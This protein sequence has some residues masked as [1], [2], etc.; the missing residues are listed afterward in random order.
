MSQLNSGHLSERFLTPMDDFICAI[1][2]EVCHDTSVVD[3]GHIFCSGC[4]NTASKIVKECPTCRKH[5]NNIQT[6][7]WH[8]IKI[9]GSHVRCIY[10]GCSFTDAL[11][12]IESHE[13]ECVFR[14]LPCS[15]CN[16][17]IL[18][19]DRDT[20]RIVCRKRPTECDFCNQSIAYDEMNHHVQEICTSIP[21]PCPNHCSTEE[22]I[23]VMLRDEIT[24]HR[25]TCLFEPV[26][27]IYSSIGCKTVTKRQHSKD[28]END[29]SAHF[30]LLFQYTKEHE[31]KLEKE[32]EQRTKQFTKHIEEHR[33]ITKR[34]E[35]IL[36]KGPEKIAEHLHPLEL[37]M[38]LSGH[39]CD[40][41]NTLFDL[42]EK[43][44]GYRCSVTCDYDLCTACFSEK[45]I[46]KSKAMLRRDAMYRMKNPEIEPSAYEE[47]HPLLAPS[48]I[49]DYHHP[50]VVGSLVKRGPMWRWGNQDGE[51]LGKVI[52]IAEQDGWLT[53]LWLSTQF[54]NN[55]RAGVNAEYDLVYA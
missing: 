18:Y 5:Y 43:S 19:K 1:C 4:I 16:D 55:Y 13:K 37:C 45:R 3:C 54:I 35:A 49:V 15:I 34:L 46:I 22:P 9:N 31:K 7:P 40:Q 24:I 52:A 20:H 38:D 12:R 25:K 36:P 33:I 26:P 44:I 53:V 51:G 39:R 2:R 27:C 14:P 10:Q 21:L 30:E 42:D 23:P 8:R 11:E 47:I 29:I 48:S 17:T 28:H 41:C 32:M 6:S 50:Y